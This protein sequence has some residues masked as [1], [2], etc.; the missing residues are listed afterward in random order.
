MAA[1]WG[2]LSTQ[3]QHQTEVARLNTE[4]RKRGHQISQ[5]ERDLGV[6]MLVLGQDWRGR[7]AQDLVGAAM[8]ALRD[9]TPTEEN[10]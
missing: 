6:L 9:N 1:G 2:N 10:S 8:N 4:L 7:V 5:L 3:R